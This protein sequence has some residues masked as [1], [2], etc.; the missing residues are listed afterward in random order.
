MTRPRGIIVGASARRKKI[1]RA[2]VIGHVIALRA[3]F[4]IGTSRCPRAGNFLR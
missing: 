4:C 3:I 2:I 1:A